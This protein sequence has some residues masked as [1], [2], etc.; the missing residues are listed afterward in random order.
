MKSNTFQIIL[1]LVVMALLVYNIYMSKLVTT[2]V[3]EYKEKIEDVQ[4][5]LDSSMGAGSRLDDLLIKLD[6]NIISIGRDI[7]KMNED[8]KEIKRNTDE[9][10]RAID[11][12][13]NSELQLFFAKRYQ[14]SNVK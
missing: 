11:T 6:E 12:L 4:S 3:K 2:N 10:V 1:L 5:K 9:K 14:P 8:I 13:N 7:Y